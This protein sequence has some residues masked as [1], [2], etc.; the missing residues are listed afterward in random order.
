MHPL[1]V[2]FFLGSREITIGTYGVLMVIAIAAGIALFVF[3]AGKRGGKRGDYFSIGVFAA[4]GAI[5]GAII[6]GAVLFPPLLMNGGL[7]D[8]QPVL[9]SWGGIMGGIAALA[10][11]GIIWRQGFLEMADTGTPAY[12]AG[13]GIGRIGCFFGGCCYGV[14]ASFC[15]VTFTDALAP[16]AAMPQPLVPVQLYSAAFLMAAGA[17]CILPAIRNH[18]P[19]AVFGSSAI[20]YSVFRFTIE[21]WRDDPRRFACGLSDGQIWSIVFGALGAALLARSLIRGTETAV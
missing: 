7:W 21:F 4:A 17:A 14:H 13:M 3:C 16:A 1:L 9:V 10:A 11:G 20:L 12:L 8:W 15:G 19:G 5:G 6:A 18:R 2:K